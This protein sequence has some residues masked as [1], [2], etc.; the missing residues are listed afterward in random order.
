MI[1][2]KQ[3]IDLTEEY[4]N[5]FNVKGKTVILFVNPTGSELKSLKCEEFRFTADSSNKKVYVWNGELALH[6]DINRKLN[7]GSRKDLLVGEALLRGSNLV[8]YQSDEIEVSIS[9]SLNIFK[10][11]VKRQ[12]MMTLLFSINWSWLERYILDSSKYIERRRLEFNTKM[13]KIKKK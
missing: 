8:M 2:S 1:T 7:L 5:T 6:D 9:P 3:V 11:N 13:D 12:Q 4:N 10:D